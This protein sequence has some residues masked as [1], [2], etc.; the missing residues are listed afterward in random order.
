MDK[1]SYFIKNKALFGSFPKEDAVKELEQ[2]GVRY[3]ID[4]TDNEIETKIIPYTT[5]YNYINF[6][7]KDNSVPKDWI[8]FSK[9]IIRLSKIIK[10]E[11]KV[12]EKIYIHCRGGHGRSGVVVSCLLCFM[13]DL[14][15]HE[16]LDYTTLCHKNRTVMR[17]KWRK[18]GSPQTSI[19]KK[20]VFKF[21]QPLKIYHAYKNSI[22]IGFSNISPHP[23]NIE[24]EIFENS[25]LAIK[26]E[27]EKNFD[28][29]KIL[30][31]K[32]IL[33]L[34]FDQNSNIRKNLI[35]TGLR[36]LIYISNKNTTDNKNILGKILTEI[37]NKYYEEY[38][39]I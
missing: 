5:K 14:T 1:A 29:N 20:F 37:R 3:F 38:E 15:Q 32:E 33:Q 4:L 26:A 18:I 7:I 21:F 10:E 12:D 24:G 22:S 34:K 30:I 19:Q 6:P 23:V 25:E 28:N 35:N 31:I 8:L 9:F 16:A 11:M 13:F 2:E 17:D 39:E 27:F 36:P